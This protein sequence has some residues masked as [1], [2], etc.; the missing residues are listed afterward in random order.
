MDLGPKQCFGLRPYKSDLCHPSTQA[1]IT[2]QPSTSLETSELYLALCPPL[3]TLIGCSSNWSS[4]FLFLLPTPTLP[5]LPPLPPPPPPPTP[6]TPPTPP[7]TRRS[8]PNLNKMRGGKC[9]PGQQQS[10][11]QYGLSQARYTSSDSRLM[12]VPSRIQGGHLLLLTPC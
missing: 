7:D 9:A 3:F 1:T 5:T 12:P 10:N 2:A 6:P 11:T 8:M 4:T